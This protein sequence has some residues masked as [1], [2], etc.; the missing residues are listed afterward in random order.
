MVYRDMN[1]VLTSNLPSTPI[2]AVYQLM[3]QIGEL[4]RIAWIPPFKDIENK[5]FTIA[6][7]LFEAH[8][9][10]RLETF[11]MGGAG[12]ESSTRVEDYD[13]IYLSGGDPVKFRENLIQSNLANHLRNLIKNGK[14]IVA[15]SGGSMQLAKNVSVFRLINLEVEQVIAERIEYEALG[16]VPYEFLPHLNAHSE[17]FL[18]KVRQ[19]SQA[20]HHPVIGVEDGGALMHK[21]RDTYQLVGRASIF[22]HGDIE[23]IE[24][25]A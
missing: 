7:R 25:E 24:G 5:R 11:S 12:I 18:E 4:P 15:S 22:R 3:R 9:F 17:S 19:Y 10:E 14:M 16:I 1:L 21:S 8:G 13:V 23:S 20:I 2:E 6:K